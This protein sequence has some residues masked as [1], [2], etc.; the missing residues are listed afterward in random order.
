MA[1]YTLFLLL[2]DALIRVSIPN[3]RSADLL[4]VEQA[5]LQNYMGFF[6]QSFV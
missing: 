6:E 2:E 4:L 3:N 5:R 1:K